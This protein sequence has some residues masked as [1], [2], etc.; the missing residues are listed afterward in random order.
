M[1]LP[2]RFQASYRDRL[3]YPESLIPSTTAVYSSKLR[4]YKNRLDGAEEDLCLVD[5]TDDV[6]E[7]FEVP[8]IDLD[9]ADGKGRS[10]LVHFCSL[11]MTTQLYK[12]RTFTRQL[13]SPNGWAW[14]S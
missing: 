7:I 10:T 4:S 6:N 3:S 9:T 12:L 13:S 14:S 2:P 11:L 8:I 5:G 1:T